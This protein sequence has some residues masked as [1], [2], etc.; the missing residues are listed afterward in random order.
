MIVIHIAVI[1]LLAVILIMLVRRG[2]ISVDMS[3]P[4]LVAIIVLGTLS[5]SRAFVEFVAGTL[6]ILYP[7]IAIVFMTIFI[8]LG[9]ITALLVG[10]SRIRKRQIEIVRRLAA[11]ELAQQDLRPETK[12]VSK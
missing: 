5:T 3:F 8:L 7:P 1:A 2:L 12:E 6:G 11:L 10:Y 4:W 9:L